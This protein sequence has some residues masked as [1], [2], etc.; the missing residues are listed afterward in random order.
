MKSSMNKKIA[1]M[2][3]A[4]LTGF[5]FVISALGSNVLGVNAKTTETVI[6]TER[7]DKVKPASGSAIDVK[8]KVKPASGSAIDSK[9]KVKPT[10]DTPPKSPEKNNNT[11]K[12]KIKK[13]K[14]TAKNK[15]KITLSG[16][17]TWSNAQVI[18]KTS[19]EKNVKAKITKKTSTYCVIQTNKKLEKNT[20]IIK[21]KGIKVKGSSKYETITTK[22]KVK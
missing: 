13:T 9:D 11:K 10:T 15:I 3:I 22:I 1:A 4:G 20:Y 19:E 5:A 12:V 2:G 8:D 7:K 17:N 16:T 6:V 14:K 18:I 21:L